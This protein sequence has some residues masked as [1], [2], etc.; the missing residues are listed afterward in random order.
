[1]S[2][3]QI[4]AGITA[5]R[6]KLSEIQSAETNEYRLEALQFAQGML[7]TLWR[8]EFVNEEQFEQL[9]IDLLNADSQ[10]L[11]TLKLSIL[12]PNHG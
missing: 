1:M 11:R 8:I 10:A 12:E 4:D 5:F 7:F 6:E 9:K 2:K 3:E